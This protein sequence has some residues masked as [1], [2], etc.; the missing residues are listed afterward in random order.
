MPPRYHRNLAGAKPGKWLAAQ[1]R[2]VQAEGVRG[3]QV[4][5]GGNWAAGELL[6]AE[7]PS[8]CSALTFARKLV[9][10]NWWLEIGVLP[11]AIAFVPALA[12]ATRHMEILTPCRSSATPITCGDTP[13]GGA[14]SRTAACLASVRCS[15]A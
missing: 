4:T 10:G 11:S 7:L 2:G 5:G 9:A 13:W 3:L 1:L 15:L 8:C 6:I 14:S 12:T